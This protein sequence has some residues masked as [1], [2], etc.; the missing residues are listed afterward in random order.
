MSLNY[1]HDSDYAQAEMYVVSDYAQAEMYVM[2]L[3]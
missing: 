1:S 3:E 2:N